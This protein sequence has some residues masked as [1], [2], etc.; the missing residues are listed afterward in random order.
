MPVEFPDLPYPSNALQPH[1]SAEAL[2]LRHGTHHRACVDAVNA[3]IA[4]T[5]FAEMGL[6][7]IVRHSQGS[8]FEAAAQAWNHG[9]QWQCLHPRGGGEPD[10]PLAERI[11]RHFGDTQRL[12]EEFNRVALSIFGSGWTW[13]VQHP[14][15][16]LTVIGTRN[17]AT[18][19]TGDSIPLLACCVWEHAYYLD[20]RNDRASYL[21]AFWKLANWDFAASRLS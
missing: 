5:E 20:Y 3:G 19:L 14:D 18:P 13:L 2:E 10:G 16:A 6:E 15:G 12:R 7:E 4:G 1:L 8:L 17:A 21:D 9:F 11:A